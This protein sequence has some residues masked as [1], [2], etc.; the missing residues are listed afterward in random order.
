MVNSV[1]PLPLLVQ[2]PSILHN[3]PAQTLSTFGFSPMEASIFMTVGLWITI[4]VI[5][6]GQ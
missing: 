4:G 1:A 2:A 6:G 5:E 3:G